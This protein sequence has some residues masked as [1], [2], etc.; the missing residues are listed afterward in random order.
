MSR[1]RRFPLPSPAMIIAMIALLAA[2]AG[3]A[4]ANHGG[5]HGPPGLVNS[6]DVADGSLTGV[7]IRNRSLTPADFR[8]SVRG[9]RGA[10][11]RPGEPGPPG[12]PGASGQQGPPGPPGPPGTSLLNYVTTSNIDN[13]PQELTQGNAYCPA[14]QYPVGGGASTSAYYQYVNE[15]RP[16]RP[17]N[18]WKVYVFNTS[19]TAAGTFRVYVVCAPAATVIGSTGPAEVGEKVETE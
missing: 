1:R 19:T 16:E 5:P 14:G 11:G 17:A 6:L 7:D 13:G 9:K 3:S 15:S 4:I 12:T 10:P 18:G 2:T 8:G